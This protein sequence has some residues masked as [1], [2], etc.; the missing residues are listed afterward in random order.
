MGPRSYWEMHGG[1]SHECIHRQ[2]EEGRKQEQMHRQKKEGREQGKKKRSHYWKEYWMDERGRNERI[3]RLYYATSS[4]S[5]NPIQPRLHFP[6]IILFLSSLYEDAS[7]L[8]CYFL[9]SD[10]LFKFAFMLYCSRHLVVPCVLSLP[11][12]A[13]FSYFSPYPVLYL[14]TH[15]RSSSFWI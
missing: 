10:I 2:I 7:L 9:S 6:L 3:D 12:P 8:L 14:I 5:S 15:L 1:K 11:P 4:N 13:T